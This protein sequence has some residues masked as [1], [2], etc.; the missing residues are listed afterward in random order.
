MKEQEKIETQ[1][2]GNWTVL[3]LML[4]D[5]LIVQILRLLLTTALFGVLARLHWLDNNNPD[6]KGQKGFEA[7][8]EGD[9]SQAWNSSFVMKSDHKMP[10]Q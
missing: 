6:T 2:K 10:S 8:I 7:S 4:G 5:Q 1:E 3:G 9:Q